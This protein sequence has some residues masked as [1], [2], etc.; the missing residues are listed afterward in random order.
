M[1]ET[2]SWNYQ[3]TQI[4][5]VVNSLKKVSPHQEKNALLQKQKT[6]K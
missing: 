4:I 5:M 1:I 6:Q 2:V 3:Y